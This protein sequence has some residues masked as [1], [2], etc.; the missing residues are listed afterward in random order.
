MC[1]NRFSERSE[2]HPTYLNC[3]ACHTVSFRAEGPLGDHLIHPFHFVDGM[4]RSRGR[5]AYTRTQPGHKA[6]MTSHRWTTAEVK[7]G[8]SG[9]RQLVSRK[10]Q[11]GWNFIR[12]LPWP[13][14]SSLPAA[15]IAK[16]STVPN[17]SEH[18]G[19]ASVC[20]PGHTYRSMPLPFPRGV[21]E[22]L[23]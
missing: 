3:H 4:A 10:P 18:T 19:R 1:I 13:S 23:P 7:E 8:W 14:V 22:P 12:F 15:S 21:G 5:G 20:C 9:R 17:S 6:R 2:F 16:P 11:V